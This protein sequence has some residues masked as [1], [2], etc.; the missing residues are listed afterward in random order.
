M[1]KLLSIIIPAYNSERYLSRCL[2]SLISESIMN[3]VE[4][5][6]VNDG[7]KDKTSEIAHSYEM[8]YPNYF[9]VVDKE[10]GNYGSVMNVGL[11]K[12][13]GK[14][15]KTLD[16]D[17][18]YDTEALNSYIKE[19]RVTNADLVLCDYTRYNECDGS[20]KTF[21]ADDKIEKSRDI[22]ITEDIWNFK[23]YYNIHCT[24]Y[25]TEL[26]KE[27]GIIW[28]E[29]VFYSDI[30]T[31]FW[32]ERLCK[33]V[34]FIPYP[35]YVYLEGRNDQSMSLSSKIKNFNSYN[36]V[37]NNILD[38]FIHVY[39]I[40]NPM[41]S[42]QVRHLTYILKQLYSYLLLFEFKDKES[43]KKIDQKLKSV[44]FIYNSLSETQ[45]WHGLPYI[46]LFRQEFSN[47]VNMRHIIF[48]AGV[49]LYYLK[50][51]VQL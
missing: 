38:E 19:L 37:A 11:N 51:K 22:I 28:P 14:Y 5:I 31:L 43:I 42:Q 1:K 35:V 26:L 40:H 23:T 25:K 45:I 4:V 18:W 44:P 49:L 9:I 46:K 6:V 10:N 36:I 27:S 21:V 50:R 17:D 13:K 2:D 39:D 12:A 3:D 32:P 16:S 48:K 29:N 7:S 15:F 34:R 47:K 24:S 8:K 33:T 30:Q 41:H 20:Y